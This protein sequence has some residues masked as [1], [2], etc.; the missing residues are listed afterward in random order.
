LRLAA[1]ERYNRY[2]MF[3]QASAVINTERQASREF[4]HVADRQLFVSPKREDNR[5]Q[6]FVFAKKRQGNRQNNKKDPSLRAAF[7]QFLVVL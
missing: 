7:C 4:Y 6:L 2:L 1:V 5:Q 3:D